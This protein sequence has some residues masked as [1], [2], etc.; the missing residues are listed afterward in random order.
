MRRERPERL[1]ELTDRL[2]HLPLLGPQLLELF[3]QVP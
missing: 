2:G 3:P 1:D